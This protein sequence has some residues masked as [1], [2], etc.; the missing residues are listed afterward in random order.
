M[1]VALE[2]RALGRPASGVRTYVSRLLEALRAS[3]VEV[4]TLESGPG[5][6]GLWPLWMEM[7]VPRWLAQVRPSV[8]HFTKAAL[9]LGS[10]SKPHIPTVVTIYDVIPML[11]PQSQKIGPRL[12]W[13]AVLRHAGRMADHI[14]TISEA[15]KRDIVELLQVAPEKVTVTQLAVD[16]RIKRQ[17]ARIKS[18]TTPY[19][20]FLSTLEPRKNVPALI[21]SYSKIAG[22]IPHRL[23]IAGRS[24]KGMGEIEREIGRRQLQ[25]RVKLLGAVASDKLTNLY[26]DA[27]LFVL[28]SV[29]EGWSFPVQEAMSYGVPVLVSNGG[30]L[31]EV[32]GVAGS[33]VP[34]S[35]GSVAAR[36]HDEAFESALADQ[37]LGVLGDPARQ[38]FM[39]EAGRARTHQRSWR[40]VALA[41]I[42]VYKNVIS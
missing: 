5:L 40:D 38:S 35:A 4:E 1:R 30:A 41:T 12:L 13:P 37:M 42:E 28:P 29:Y 7:T 3:G 14:I 22:Q 27:S 18:T 36:T 24:Y 17:E 39:T 25:D 2:A 11:F 20:L 33:V 32:V 9:P 23:L 6:V 10:H 15:S 8:V 19:I 31:P 16:V 21:R 26:T 34:F